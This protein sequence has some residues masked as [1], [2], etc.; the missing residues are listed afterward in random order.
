MAIASSGLYLS[1]NVGML[2]GLSVADCIMRRG[3]D[4]GLRIALEGWHGGDG[5]MGRREIIRRAGSDVEFVRGLQGELGEV[6]RKVWVGSL[7]K[8]HGMFRFQFFC[9]SGTLMS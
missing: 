3:L 8:T 2:V 1:S 5:G 9:A 7:G 6:V 4:T